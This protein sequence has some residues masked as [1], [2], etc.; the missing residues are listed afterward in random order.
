MCQNNLLENLY[1]LLKKYISRQILSLK[2]KIAY[3][4]SLI[5]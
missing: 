2:L 5:V 4:T 1:F 3:W